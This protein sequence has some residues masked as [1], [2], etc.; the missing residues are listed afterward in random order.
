MARPTATR[1]HMLEEWGGRTWAHPVKIGRRAV[2]PEF[3]RIA[4]KQDPGHRRPHGVRRA[5][6]VAVELEP[7][8]VLASRRALLRRRPRRSGAQWYVRGGAARGREAHISPVRAGSAAASSAP[9]RGTAAY[10]V[11]TGRA[12]SLRRRNDIDRRHRHF[13]RRANG[14]PGHRA[15]RFPHLKKCSHTRRPPRS[16]TRRS[17]AG[18]TAQAAPRRQDETFRQEPVSNAMSERRSGGGPGQARIMGLSGR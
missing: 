9:R 3:W 7:S 12:Q 4:T 14:E 13:P 10:G 1:S 6:D 5:D 11:M 16:A 2:R 8:S 18:R 15:D 17:S